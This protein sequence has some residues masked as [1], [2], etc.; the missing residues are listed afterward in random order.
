[1]KLNSFKKE[2]IEFF[3][4]QHQPEEG[5]FETTQKDFDDHF[6][7]NLNTLETLKR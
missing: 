7:K 5:I 4:Q 1:M 3:Q 6:K 2:I